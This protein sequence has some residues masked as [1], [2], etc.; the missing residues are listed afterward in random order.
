MTNITSIQRK[1]EAIGAR[2]KFGALPQSLPARA[3]RG[4][5]TGRRMLYTVDLSK[6]NVDQFFEIRVSDPDK[7]RVDLSVLD[8]QPH[9]RHL[10]LMAKAWAPDGARPLV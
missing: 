1:F 8:L 4:D 6:D 3:R 9:D 10:L 2:A 7:D 5:I